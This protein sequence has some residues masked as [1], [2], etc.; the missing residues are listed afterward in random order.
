LGRAGGVGGVVGFF[1]SVGLAGGGVGL[2]GVVGGL[3]G[4]VVGLTGVA[5]VVGDCRGGVSGGS[6]GSSAWPKTIAVENTHA[7]KTEITLFR[8]NALLMSV[9]FHKL[10]GFAW[11][12]GTA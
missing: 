12:C 8:L 6:C 7:D 11:R 3:A 10:I 2:T 5:G 1:G 4:G 9:T